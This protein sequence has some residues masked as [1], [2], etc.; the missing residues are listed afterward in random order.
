MTDIDGEITSEIL[1]EKFKSKTQDEWVAIFQDLD[2]CVSPVLTLD[3]AVHNKHNNQRKSFVKT[4]D[5]S[6][7]LP[8]MN[9]LGSDS[10]TNLKLP[11]IGQHSTSI[12]SK[13]GY[14]K[15]EIQKFLD[16]KIIEQKSANHFSKL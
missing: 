3:E 2:A 10:T 16:E 8:T 11:E 14:S 7:W 5:E 13:M 6:T 4:H 15:E 12:L 1:S 9:W